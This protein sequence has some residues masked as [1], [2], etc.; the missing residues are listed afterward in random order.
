MSRRI[1]VVRR[2]GDDGSKPLLEDGGGVH[3]QAIRWLFA[4]RDSTSRRLGGCDKA[5]E[6]TVAWDPKGLIV[7]AVGGMRIR[8]GGAVISRRT[9]EFT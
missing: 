2:A 9:N 4:I 3:L 5:T 1:E 8:G 6:S 7:K